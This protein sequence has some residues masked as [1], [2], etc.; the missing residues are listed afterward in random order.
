MGFRHGHADRVGDAL[1]ERAGG[2][3]D[4]S[5]DVVL[6]VAGRERA[7]LAELPARRIACASAPRE[8]AHAAGALGV[9]GRVGDAYQR[10]TGRARAARVRDG[11]CDGACV[12]ACVGTCVGGWL[13]QVVEREVVAGQV[14]HAVLERARVTVREHEA[15][16]VGP[17]GVSR[18]VL[19]HLCPQLVRDWGA[20]HCGTRVAR[21][22]LLHHV[23]RQHTHQID[24]PL[25]QDGRRIVAIGLLLLCLPHAVADT[26]ERRA[27]RG[28]IRERQ[29][30]REP[31]LGRQVAEV[32]LEHL[33][34]G[35][36]EARFGAT[37]ARGS[38]RE[39]RR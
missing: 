34:H 17:L 3:L 5:G 1:A 27:L 16:A 11:A 33:V 22:G 15:V 26:E 2:D 20:A 13:P 19:H 14:E 35:D 8:S 31:A 4:A 12:G 29:V 28:E 32:V 37:A 10:S 9:C 30:G 38:S 39:R 23:R 25:L 36:S 7:Q 21:V 24:A 6:R 18:R